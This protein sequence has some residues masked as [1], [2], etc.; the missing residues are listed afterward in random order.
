MSFHFPTSRHPGVRFHLRNFTALLFLLPLILPVHS[1]GNEI[2]DLQNFL[3]P[4]PRFA[5][6]TPSFHWEEKTITMHGPNGPYEEKMQIIYDHGKAV[7]VR[8]GRP[9][10]D[11]ITH[12]PAQAPQELEFPVRYHNQTYFHAT[13]TTVAWFGK[14]S[15]TGDQHQVEFS[16]GGETLTL[17]ESQIWDGTKG[18]RGKSVHRFTLRVDPVLGYVVD[19]ELSYEGERPL[20]RNKGVTTFELS[21]FLVRDVP[22]PWS[23]KWRYDHTVLSKSGLPEKRFAGWANNNPAGDLSDNQGLPMREGGLVAFLR[24]GEW[25]PA[26]SR[27]GN[28]NFHQKTCNVWQDQHNNAQFPPEPDADGEYRFRSRVLLAFLPP[29]VTDYVWNNT[30]WDTFNQRKQVVIRLGQQEN[31]ETQPLPLTSTRRGMT[32]G[33]VFL[34][35]ERSVSGETSLLVKSV[36]D[37]QSRGTFFS[38]PQIGLIP[39]T[40]YRIDA[41]VWVE[42]GSRASITADSYEWTPHNPERLE[43]FETNVA[44]GSG[45]WEKL[46]LNI[47]AH[48]WDPYVDIRFRV[49]GGGQAWFDD[50][51]IRPVASTE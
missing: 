16:E 24:Q 45:K 49:T 38:K 31:F 3:K 1:Y 5:A 18:W 43:R 14:W 41:M 29:E 21:N 9:R 2:R 11:L 37:P 20:H 34:S 40:A 25:S 46:T 48:T 42:E 30:E 6:Y 33:R 26:F 10:L 50:V 8:S 22:T 15:I 19:G 36:K 7:A 4:P 23:G 13:I 17:T 32:G 35:T 12:D 51:H 39:H 47:P 28:L 44:E 27:S